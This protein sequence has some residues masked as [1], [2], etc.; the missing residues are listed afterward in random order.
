ML[1]RALELDGGERAVEVEATHALLAAGWIWIDVTAGADDVEELVGLADQL[2]LDTL[3]SR[4]ATMLSTAGILERHP[5]LHVVFVEFSTAWLAWILETMDFYDLAF[6][7]YEAASPGKEIIYPKL[8]EPPSYYVRRQVHST[9]QVDNVGIG[10]VAH[11][12]AQCLMWGNDYPHE[13]WTYPHSREL[14]DKQAAALDEPT[15]RR[16]FRENALEI[17][18]FDEAVLDSPGL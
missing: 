10:N 16:V 2:G 11:T 4:V 12:G 13:E 6:R 15:A 7:E 5:G 9:F 14:V 3:A 1:I 17:F 8:D 18:R